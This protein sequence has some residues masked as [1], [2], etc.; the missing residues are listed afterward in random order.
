M[1]RLHPLAFEIRVLP[2]RADRYRLA[3]WQQVLRPNGSDRAEARQLATL[4][5]TPLEIALDQILDTLRREGH[6][7]TALR[8]GQQEPL[9]I[10][11]EAGVRLGLLFL[12]LRPL[13][14]V[15]RMEAVASGIRAMPAEE[16]YYWFSKCVA[17][18]G[19]R[20][21]QRA[22]RVLLGRG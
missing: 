6:R 22:L 19:G 15:T 5:G 1:S 17:D 9:P 11:E 16:A 3:L 18:G 13:T 14:K 20:Q 21:A 4:R 7:L 10:S 8:V 12:A 2:D